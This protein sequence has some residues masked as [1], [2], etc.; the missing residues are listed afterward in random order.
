MARFVGLGL[1]GQGEHPAGRVGLIAPLGVMRRG[2]QPVFIE[3]CVR[4]KA[5]RVETGQLG[6]FVEVADGID[7]NFAEVGHAGESHQE[8]CSV[9]KR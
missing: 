4:R 3:F 7:R 2:E 6:P 8:G 5:G 1:A 9:G